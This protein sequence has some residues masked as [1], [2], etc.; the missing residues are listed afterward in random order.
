MDIHLR[1]MFNTNNLYE[2]LNGEF[3]DRIK[4][5]RG[6]NHPPDDASD[7]RRGGGCPGLV[8][9]MIVYHNFFREHQGLNGIT[10]AEAAGITIHGE[11]KWAT[12][13]ANAALQAS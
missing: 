5:V 4:T 12:M 8:R 13:I 11:N 9:L 10:P 1:G 2:R 6:F 3:E 7:A